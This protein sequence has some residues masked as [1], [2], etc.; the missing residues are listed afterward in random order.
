M[1]PK[2][3][4]ERDVAMTD[5]IPQKVKRDD[6]KDDPG[7]GAIPIPGKLMRTQAEQDDINLMRIE[8]E[9]NKLRMDAKV[10][11]M[12]AAVAQLYGQQVRMEE[13]NRVSQKYDMF[14]RGGAS[15]SP[16]GCRFDKCC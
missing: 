11:N 5:P 2:L 16:N 14:T 15:N 12:N 8:A 3:K 1:P 9:K 6:D 13:A 10:E 7:R 4:Q